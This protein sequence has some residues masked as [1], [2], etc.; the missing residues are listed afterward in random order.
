MLIQYKVGFMITIIQLT[1][2]SFGVKEQSSATYLKAYIL[3]HTHSFNIYLCTYILEK[4]LKV[5]ILH[6]LIRSLQVLFNHFIF[7]Q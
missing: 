1:I 2:F 7:P 3:V 4:N 6:L 5:K